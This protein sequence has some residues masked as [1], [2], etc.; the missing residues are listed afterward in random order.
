MSDFWRAIVLLESLHHKWEWRER[1]NTNHKTQFSNSTF[2]L[3]LF[4]NFTNSSKKYN[5][6]DS[7]KYRREICILYSFPKF[8]TVPLPKSWNIQFRA[9]AN[10]RN[11]LLWSY[12]WFLTP[13]IKLT[14]VTLNSEKTGERWEA[15]SKK[16]KNCKAIKQANDQI[17]T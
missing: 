9:V 12:T 5:C 14:I 17:I 8:S 10:L 2:L 4:Q 11:V 15:E 1:K 7:R 13:E 16:K 3:S 6:S